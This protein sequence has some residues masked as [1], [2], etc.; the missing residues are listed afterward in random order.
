M[1]KDAMLYRNNQ[2]KKIIE[3]TKSNDRIQEITNILASNLVE[4]SQNS[5]GNYA[6]Q[7][8]LDTWGM[9]ICKCIFEEL[10]K[11][12]TKLAIDRYSSNVVEKFI[13]ES[14]MVWE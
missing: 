11:N 2:I 5:Y 9:S 8:A 4:L 13:L 1:A 6:V 7:Y 14:N 10:Q 12:L 3:K